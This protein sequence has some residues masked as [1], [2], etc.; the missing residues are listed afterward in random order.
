MEFENLGNLGRVDLLERHIMQ[1]FFNDDLTVT[2]EELEEIGYQL[3]QFRYILGN[4]FLHEN[5]LKSDEYK[6]I[7]SIL[8]E[9]EPMYRDYNK[10]TAKKAEN[11]F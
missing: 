4:L 7:T 8:D 5:R 1:K 2:K 3:K 9:L 11:V 6:T 10:E